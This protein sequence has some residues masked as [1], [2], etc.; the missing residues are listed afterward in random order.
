MPSNSEG[1]VRHH[2]RWSKF[3]LSEKGGQKVC[4]FN[5]LP[6]SAMIPGKN[7]GISLETGG[8]GFPFTKVWSWDS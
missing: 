6:S 4:V 7:S 1:K 5:C 3:P 2:L 8:Q